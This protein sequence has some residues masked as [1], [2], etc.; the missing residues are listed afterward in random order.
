M[1]AGPLSRFAVLDLTRAR[2]GPTAVRQLADWGARVI[3]IEEPREPG[4]NEETGGTRHGADFQNLHRNK[5]SLT[6]NLKSPEGLSIFKQL[7]EHADVVVENYRANVK[8]RLG[9]D[10]ETLRKINPRLVYGSISGFGQDGPYSA[11]P[12][13]DQ[14]AQGM[15]GLMSITGEP[16][17]GPMRVGI[18]IADLTTGV[19]CAMGILIALLEREQSGQGQWVQGS[20]LESQISMLDFQAT[21]WLIEG[22]VPGQAGN[23]HPTI[24]PTGVFPTQDGHINLSADGRLIW[25]RLCQELGLDALLGDPELETNEG[26]SRNR[27][28]VNAAIASVT[29]TASTAEW[30][31]RL[32]DAG[33]PCGPINTIDKV[34]AD[35]QVKHLDI[36]KTL[37]H[38]ALGEVTVVGQPVHLTRTPS[39]IHTAAPERG[40]HSD[41]ILRELGH[42]A[43]TIE[44]LR[45]ARII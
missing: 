13:F 44:R 28:R 11:R 6:L 5:R 2:A 8:F 10:Y 16:G 38:P 12:G 23:D 7:V 33:V 4:D 35:P 1:I 3:R 18:P 25:T 30:V 42:D 21:R 45:A 19:F 37:P 9:I 17:R 32:N 39:V 27:Q 34:F 15:G 22:V 31:R 20:L 24:I 41:E 43:G 26:R 36:A 14:V 40:A 29:A